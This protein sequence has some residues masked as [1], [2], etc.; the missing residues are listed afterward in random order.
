MARIT[1]SLPRVHVPDVRTEVINWLLAAG[2]RKRV[3]PGARI[4]ITAGSRG[5]GG[6][7]ELLAG[8]KQRGAQEAHRHGLWE[9]V[10]PVPR[11]QLARAPVL[12]GISVVENGY[13]R[14]AAIEVVPASFDAFLEA[15]LRLLKIAQG[16]LAQIPFDALDL[17]I[18]D[19]LGKNISGA[20]MDPNVI[21]PARSVGTDQVPFRRI[22][23]LS[24]AEPALGNGL[25]IGM[26]D[27]TTQR[28]ADAYDPTVTYVNLLTATGPGGNNRDT[29]EISELWVSEALLGEVKRNPALTL[30]EPPAPLRFDARGD[31]L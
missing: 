11:L 31:L 6:F 25:G 20:G 19:E 2:L 1:Q 7:P 5:I 10:R 29:A 17:L 3:R 12:F 18:V 15:D 26:A 4:A 9:S 27:F 16:Y 21:G 13:R 22:V 30:V 28:F 8:G 24:L 23:V 14:P